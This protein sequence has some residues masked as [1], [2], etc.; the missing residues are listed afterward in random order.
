MI[1]I[2]VLVVAALLAAGCAGQIS[3]ESTPATEDDAGAALRSSAPTATAVPQ[4]SAPS[5]ALQPTATPVEASFEIRPGLAAAERQAGLQSTV[6]GL[7]VRYDGQ[8]VQVRA[9]YRYSLL[10]DGQ[11]DPRV[12]VPVLLSPTRPADSALASEV[13]K[14][15]NLWIANRQLERGEVIVS[16]SVPASVDSAPIG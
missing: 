7:L 6:E 2:L 15:T 5:S 9:E 8:E 16:V 13:A 14:D 1:R 4:E 3:T 12:T 10:A 11:A